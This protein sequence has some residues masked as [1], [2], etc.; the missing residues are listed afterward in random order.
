MCF[1]EMLGGLYYVAT[2]LPLEVL[3]PALPPAL[4]YS[5]TLCVE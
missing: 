2:L 5:W 3:P 1:G 4:H